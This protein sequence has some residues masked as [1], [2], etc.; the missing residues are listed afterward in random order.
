[1]EYKKIYIK[2]SISLCDM[3]KMILVLMASNENATYSPSEG[4]DDDDDDRNP[5][6]NSVG[7]NKRLAPGS[8]FGNKMF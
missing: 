4:N 7:G 8:P 2:P 1:M 3:D 6:L 5:N